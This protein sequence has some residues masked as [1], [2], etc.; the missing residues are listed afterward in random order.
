[1]A[2]RERPHL[3]DFLRGRR[4]IRQPDDLVTQRALGKQMGDVGARAVLLDGLVVVR[5]IDRSGAAIPGDDRGASL[6]QRVEVC[7]GLRLEN[8]LVAMIVQVNESRRDDQSRAVD[9]LRR[10][11]DLKLS[12]CDDPV[13]VDG[14]ISGRPVRAGPVDDDAVSQDEVGGDRFVREA[15][16]SFSQCNNDKP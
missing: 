2:F 8:L 9:G 6:S 4:P 10:S 7:T 11:F 3:L 13:P 5:R 16:G 15:D 12:D 1:M 14:E